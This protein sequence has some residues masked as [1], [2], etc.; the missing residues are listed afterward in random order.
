MFARDGH[1]WL[2]VFYPKKGMVWY[3]FSIFAKT[4]LNSHEQRQEECH[5]E[6]LP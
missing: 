5:V 2:I 4:K 6:I 3:F 1:G